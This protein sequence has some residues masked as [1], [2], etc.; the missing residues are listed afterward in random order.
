[1]NCST[2]MEQEII[3]VKDEYLSTESFDRLMK[4]IELLNKWDEESNQ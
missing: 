3:I 4:V 1:M 2:P